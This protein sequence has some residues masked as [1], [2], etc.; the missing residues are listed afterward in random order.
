MITKKTV[1]HSLGWLLY[2]AV[3]VEGLE[4]LLDSNQRI[5]KLA[6]VQDDDCLLDPFQKVRRKGLVFLDHLLCFNGVIEHL[7]EDNAQVSA[8]VKYYYFNTPVNNK[9]L[10]K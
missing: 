1:K 2:S 6:V 7:M 4:L 9:G 3:R 8:T 10:K 5:S